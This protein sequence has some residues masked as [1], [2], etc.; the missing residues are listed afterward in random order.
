MVDEVRGPLPI[1]VDSTSNGEFRPVPLTEH[2]ARANS[3]AERRIGEHAKRVGLGRRAFLQ[4]L[5]GAATTLLTLKDAFALAGNTGG[6]FSLPKESAF[7]L[8]AAAD[9]LAGDEFIFD[10][11]THLV[12]PTGAWRRSAG[13]YWAQAF[14]GDPQGRCGEEDPVACFSADRYIKH[15]FMDSDTDVAVLSFV[16]ELPENNPLSLEEADRVRV[17][18]NQMGG[19]ERLFLHAMV[20]PNA[21]PEVAPLKLMKDA[22]DRYPIKA[23]KCYTQWGPAGTGFELDS[24]D[25]GIPFIERARELG[26]R[27]ICIHK[28]IF[29]ARFPQEF[30]RCADVGRAAALYPDMN[31]IIYHSGFEI[32]RKEGP[33]DPSKA[34]R[35]VDALIKSVE[36][37]GI[38]RNANV[39]AELGT[40]WRYVMRDPTTAA[41]LLGKLFKHI[42]EENVLWGSDALWYGS[43]QDQIQAFRSF[44]IAPALIEAHG[45]PEL[46]PALKQKVFGLNGARVY[47]ID[48][49]ERRQKTETD[50]IGARKQVYRENADP[51]FE[52]YGPKTDSEYEALIAERGGLP[53]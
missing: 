25:V 7:E 40:T 29:F 14:A 10:I 1:K 45:Y 22:V 6:V 8:A 2:V 34:K 21:G 36:D 30:G 32:G 38:G 4:S 35:G 5:C 23:W 26:V 50:P 16:P 13:R 52:T 53:T 27:N 11:Q 43:P 3:E 28:G 20:I 39:Y 48:V 19:A 46:T 12:D 37:N 49:P 41:H 47:G 15:I 42:G 17:L 18:I 24:P 31:F 44:Q 51:T 33:Y 9:A